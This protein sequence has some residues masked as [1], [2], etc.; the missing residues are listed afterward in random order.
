M[1]EGFFDNGD[2]AGPVLLQHFIW[3]LGHPGTWITLL[4]W[5]LCL[6]GAIKLGRL[7]KRH[8]GSGWYAAFIAALLSFLIAYGYALKQAYDVF[9]K[10]APFSESIQFLT[11][12]SLGLNAFALVSIVW[13]V[14]DFLKRK[15]S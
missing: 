2:S 12:I 13:I 3:F 1:G 4:V 7:I 9:V 8:G 5:V 15:R 10:G 11:W 14:A 6:A